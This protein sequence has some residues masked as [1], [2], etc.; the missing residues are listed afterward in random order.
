MADPFIGEIRM[1]AGTFAPRGWAFCNGQLLAI[2]SNTALFSLLGT[3]YG[4]DGQSTFAL[5][6]LQSR[7]PVGTGTGAGLSNVVL[8]QLA[9]TEN[10]T[11]TTAQLPVHAPTVAVQV[12]IPAVTASTTAAGVPAANMNLGPVAAGGRAGSLYAPDTPDTTLKPFAATATVTPVGGG[13]PVPI[14]DPYLG[15]NFIIALEGIYPSRN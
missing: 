12:A 13:L 8:G 7:S 15:M 1:F 9:G 6:N 11:L 14:R 5:P 2:S 4:G 3:H 10:V